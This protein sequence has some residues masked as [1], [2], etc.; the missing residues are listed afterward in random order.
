MALR[1]SGVKRSSGYSSIWLAVAVAVI[2][3]AADFFYGSVTRAIILGQATL[4]IT[5]S[6]P[7]ARVIADTQDLGTT[8]L[9]QGKLL[10]GR[11]VLRIEHPYFEPVR[12][13]ILVA[14]GDLVE[15]SFTLQQGFGKLRLI[16]N[17]RG[18][19]IRLN[20]EELD[21]KT[22]VTLE[23]QLAG[24]YDVELLLDGRTPVLEQ[25]EVSRGATTRL[26]KELN[27][28][29]RARLTLQLTP[30]DAAVELV[31][32]D[33][34]YAPGMQL[35]PGEYGLKVSH[36]GYNV[37]E[38]TLTLR[39]G[40][41]RIVVDLEQQRAQ[42]AV[43]VE[44]A[45]AQVTLSAQGETLRYSEPTTL[46]AG[47]VA[48]VA[49]KPGYRTLRRTVQLGPD[50]QQISLSLEKYVVTHGRRFSDLLSGGGSG[51]ALVSLR[52]DTY[53]MG[54]TLNLGAADERPAHRVQLE[55]PFAIGVREVSRA[56]WA[57]QF[58]AAPK[59]VDPNLPQTRVSFQEIQTYLGW[60]SK[61][62]GET[63]RLPS[64]AEWE[65]AARAGNDLLYGAVSSITELCEYSNVADA[66]MKKDYSDWEVLPCD[67]GFV[68]L[69][70]VGSLKPNSFGLYDTIGNAREWLADCW[71][72]SY[73]GAPRDGSV[74][75]RRCGAWVSR[76]GSWD[77]SADDLR[78]SFR[79]RI[80]RENGELGFRVA[81]EL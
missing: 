20:G 60:L 75:G 43:L 42:L 63:Y 18:A 76:G 3:L 16:S 1:H 49:R 52:A 77:T 40:P 10:P 26:N 25:V 67:D 23:H 68:R 2:L 11:Y 9:E 55:A 47:K 30:K 21:A 15:R 62:T 51:P 6:P 35:R 29:P 66:S 38:Q 13:T 79:T 45:D 48:V 69:A 56:E 46:P 33:L 32:T 41:V 71:H 36:A 54:D 37:H 53:V 81:R 70:P 24:I 14:R 5:S 4:N 57:Q 65:Y 34:P 8:P 61:S 73:K 31:G 17:P 72:D 74:W 7:G 39:R 12:E 50:D 27:L 28:A 64:E 19:T 22:P 78:L 80:T 58:P 59:P 44:P